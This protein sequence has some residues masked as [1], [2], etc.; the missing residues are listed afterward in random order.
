MHQLVNKDFG[1]IKMHG[2]TVKKK[3]FF[4]V[5][6]LPEAFLFHDLL[7]NYA[8]MLLDVYRA[9]AGDTTHCRL[10][11]KHKDLA[12]ALHSSACLGSCYVACG[13]ILAITY[14]GGTVRTL[15]FVGSL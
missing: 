11:P 12:I 13:P 5:S 4:T 6:C 10:T 7:A 3:N 14:P 15:N 8:V 1:S 2:T 9:T